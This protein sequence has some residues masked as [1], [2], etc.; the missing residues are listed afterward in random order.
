MKTN[1]RVHMGNSPSSFHSFRD[2]DKLSNALA[3]MWAM[4]HVRHP[5]KC[6]L[7]QG[8]D[9]WLS[10]GHMKEKLFPPDLTQKIQDYILEDNAVTREAI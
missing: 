5:E 6:W 1:W 10:N 4:N 2:F 7:W 3:F 8:M 9:G